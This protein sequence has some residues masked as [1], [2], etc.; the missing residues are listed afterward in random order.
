MKW[1]SI[2]YRVLQFGAVAECFGVHVRQA[3]QSTNTT[4]RPLRPSKPKTTNTQV[5][6]ED[7][8]AFAD[9]TIDTIED[10]FMHATRAFMPAAK[11]NLPLSSEGQEE[12]PPLRATKKERVVVLGTGWG[13]HAISK[14]RV[15][16]V[17][18]RA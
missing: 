2:V 9:R 6:P 16:R 11:M 3:V 17:G 14:V 7:V 12:P 15:P 5:S 8:L 4:L 10:V 13:G 1:T 18:L